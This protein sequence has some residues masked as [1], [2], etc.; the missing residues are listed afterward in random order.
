MAHNA[1][2]PNGIDEALRLRTT[3]LGAFTP[4]RPVSHLDLLAG[5]AQQITK[6]LEAVI[7]PGQHATIYGERGVGKS[8]L[9]NLVYDMLFASGQQN[10]IPVRINCSVSMTFPEIWLEIFRQLE[11]MTQTNELIMSLP[12]HNPNGEDI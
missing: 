12:E 7:S 2:Q 4:G 1:T 9:A 8:S 5:R 11:E 10:Y 6:V 3:V